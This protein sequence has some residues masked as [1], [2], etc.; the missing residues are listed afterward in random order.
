MTW[1]NDESI[2][3][4]ELSTYQILMPES[5]ANLILEI[6]INIIGCDKKKFNKGLFY[7][8]FSN[9]RCKNQYSVQ[10]YCET[11]NISLSSYWLPQTNCFCSEIQRPV[12][13]PSRNTVLSPPLLPHTHTP[14]W[15]NSTPTPPPH[16]N[17]LLH[18]KRKGGVRCGTEVYYKICLSLSHLSNKSNSDYFLFHFWNALKM[19]ETL[20]SATKNIHVYTDVQVEKE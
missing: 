15:S 12:F 2:S 10:I 16:P 3:D 14:C 20:L 4:S 9:K 18:T 19:L 11:V 8:K 13:Y 6:T 1:N 7:M 5:Y 17:I